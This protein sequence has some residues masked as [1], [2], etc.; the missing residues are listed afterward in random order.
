MHYQ[1]ERGEGGR[2]GGEGEEER[3]EGEGEG[4]KE[5]A[6]III[7]KPKMMAF[8]N[9]V[10]LQH[11]LLLHD[12]IRIMTARNVVDIAPYHPSLPPPP[13]LPPS[14]PTPLIPTL[15]KPARDSLE[16]GSQA[17]HSSPQ[18]RLILDSLCVW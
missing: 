13:S 7:V 3:E 18:H 15:C 2:E 11:C 16:L 9:I 17:I 6:S 5:L 4:T 14:L 8:A 10:Q 12:C 1:V